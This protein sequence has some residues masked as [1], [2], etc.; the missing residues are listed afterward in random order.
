[1]Y[2]GD[3][4]HQGGNS[5]IQL[6]N[7][8][9]EQVDLLEETA[10]LDRNGIGEEG[11]ADGLAGCEMNGLGLVVAEASAAGAVEQVSQLGQ[12]EVGNFI[13]GGGLFEEGTRGF[14]ED[15]GEEGLILRE[16]A[17]E[18][19]EDLA[20]AVAG[21]LDQAEA[22]ELSQLQEER[23]ALVGGRQV[24]NA[25]EISDPEGISRVGLNLAQA[26]ATIGSDLEGVQHRHGIVLVGELIIEGQ[27]VMTGCFQA[28]RDRTRER[29]Q[30]GQQ[31]IKAL[32]VVLDTES[33]LLHSAHV[34]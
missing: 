16:D 31:A 6:S 34:I 2:W 28:D 12:V 9:L 26:T 23:G 8:V 4:V 17:V 14:Q 10:H 22:G 32:T 30:P 25:H 24:G 21:L 33:G 15:A 11:D 3:L 29:V 13:G 18:D 7:L 20:L 27:P 1:M 5:S 19:G